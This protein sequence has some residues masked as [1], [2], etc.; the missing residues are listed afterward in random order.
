MLRC[1]TFV[2]GLLIATPALAQDPHGIHPGF[3]PSDSTGAGTH[4]GMDHS[5]HG[6]PPVMDHG[7]HDGHAGH[8]DHSG[9]AGMDHGPNGGASAQIVTIPRDGAMLMGSPA[10]FEIT[11]PHPMR[12][13]TVTLHTRGGE[14]LRV[15]IEGAGASTIQTVP[16]PA[17]RPATY[18]LTW[19]AEGTD[20]HDMTGSISFM[21]H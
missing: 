3:V 8:G 4:V 5:Q 12:L 15:D 18:R 20:D 2:A 13:T 9:H 6:Q 14:E 11:F 7:G 21:V 1:L 17:L 19:R 10:Q 16:L